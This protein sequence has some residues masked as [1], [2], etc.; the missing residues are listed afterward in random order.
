[1]KK[2]TCSKYFFVYISSPENLQRKFLS[3]LALKKPTYILYES[4]VDIYDDPKTRLTIVNNYI[5]DN[6]TLHQKFK[7]WTILIINQNV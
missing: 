4:D 1:M 2:P 5:L 3:D 6:Y 7:K